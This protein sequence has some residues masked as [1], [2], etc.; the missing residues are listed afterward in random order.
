MEDFVMTIIALIIIIL[1]FIGLY[2]VLDYFPSSRRVSKD[3]CCVCGVEKDKTCT[4][5]ERTGTKGATTVT[6]YV[7]CEDC[8]IDF[9]KKN[10]KNETV[11]EKKDDKSK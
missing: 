9:C 6:S 8:I 1:V 5:K 7:I 4:Y 2:F 3:T 10:K 11:E